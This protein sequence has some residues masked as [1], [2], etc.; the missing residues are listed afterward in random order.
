MDK[1]LKYFIASLFFLFSLNTAVASSLSCFDV[2][3]MAIFGYDFDE[4]IFIGAIGNEYNSLS[5][6]NEYGAGS[7]YKSDSI[8]NEY[9]KFGSEYSSQSAFN[10]YASNPPIIVDDGYKFVGYL[11]I[12][13]AK[14]P[15]INTYEAI[16]CA[17]NSFIS[18]NRDMEDVVFKDIPKS[19]DGSYG[20]SSTDFKTSCPE[21]ASLV[22]SECF[23]NDGY[24]ALDDV[25]ITTS[26]ACQIQ[27]GPNSYGDSELCYCRSGYEWNSSQTSCI[28]TQNNQV[29]Q[30]TPNF[31]PPPIEVK[32]VETNFDVPEDDIK[33]LSAIGTLTTS[34][35]FRK[36]PSQ[37]CGVIRYYAEG[38]NL[39][40]TGEYKDGEWYRIE[41]TTDAG[42]TGEKVIGWVSKSLFGIVIVQGQE[43]ADTSEASKGEADQEVKQGLF[44]TLWGAFVSWWKS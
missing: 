28:K 17:K 25:C 35:K 7:E 18:P 27:F 11:T 40:V 42:G 3:G 15:S 22:G 20:Y 13:T 8:F 32:N 31:T 6:A 37:D 5:I 2:D 34:A 1:H 9:G 44:K 30:V 26:Q 12:N 39:V 19:S 16:A 23:C 33:P 38:S 21:N 29:L 10:E 41:G 14:F 24:L 4:W 36:C 43:K